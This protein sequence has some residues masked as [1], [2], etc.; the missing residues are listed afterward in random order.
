MLWLWC[1]PLLAGGAYQGFSAPQITFPV[2]TPGMQAAIGVI[3]RELAHPPLRS[4]AI[5]GADDIS[6]QWLKINRGYLKSLG[7]IG[8]VVNVESF[9]QLEILRSYSSIPLIAL[10]GAWAIE[11]YG[12]VYP[13]LIDARAG[14]LRQ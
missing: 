6:V 12:V 11:H 3:D 5:L 8:I 10:S 9:E 2:E 1:V 14:R 7:A 4:I 13:V